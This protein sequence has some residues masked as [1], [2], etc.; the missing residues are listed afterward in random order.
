M[1]KF[2]TQPVLSVDC[3][4]TWFIYT[5][6]YT[7]IHTL[8]AYAV[9]GKGLYLSHNLGGQVLVQGEEGYTISFPLNLEA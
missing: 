8:H 1:S 9:D 3:H 2:A 6:Y 7:H 5:I 4:V